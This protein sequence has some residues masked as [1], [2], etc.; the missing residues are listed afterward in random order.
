MRKILYLAVFISTMLL[1]ISCEKNGLNITTVNDASSSAQLKVN[2]FSLYK[3][4]ST[5]QI[6]INDERVSS[7]LALA[8]PF[9][10]GGLNTGGGSTA[11][12]LAVV[13]GD[14]KVAISVPKTLTNTDSVVLGSA[15]AT[16]VAGKKYSLFFTDTAANITSLLVEDSLSTP[17]SGYAKFKFINLMPDVPSIDLYIGTVKVASA[18]SYKTVSPSFTVPTNNASTVWAIRPAGAAVTT[19]ALITYTSGSTL[20]NQRIY[21]VFARGYNAITTTSDVRSRKISFVYNQ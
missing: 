13:T 20:G 16:L 7:T 19:T 2:F 5:F 3:N 11:D 9:P 18:I 17:D 14:S 6:K 21:T 15:T 1:F 12:Y 8:T 10:G 4:V